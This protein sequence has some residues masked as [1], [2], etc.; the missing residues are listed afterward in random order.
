MME[1]Y[2]IKMNNLKANIDHY[3]L[4]AKNDAEHSGKRSSSSSTDKKTNTEKD[5]SLPDSSSTVDTSPS[6]NTDS[7]FDF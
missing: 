4:R 6:K 5:D 7:D 3:D 1:K 2:N